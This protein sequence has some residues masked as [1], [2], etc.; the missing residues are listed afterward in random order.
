MTQ[1]SIAW[2]TSRSP[3]MCLQYSTPAAVLKGIKV[4]KGKV[5]LSVP[6]MTNKTIIAEGCRL[7]IRENMPADWSSINT[8]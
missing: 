1:T 3:W 6:C 2:S 8:T 7:V 5:Q 4:L